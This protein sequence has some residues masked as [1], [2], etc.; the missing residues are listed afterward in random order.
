[1]MHKLLDS[2][3]SASITVHGDDDVDVDDVDVDDVDVDDVRL[4]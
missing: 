2:G 4:L 1:M 3:L